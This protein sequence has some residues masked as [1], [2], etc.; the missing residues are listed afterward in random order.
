[1]S[2]WHWYWTNAEQWHLKLSLNPNSRTPHKWN[3]LPIWIFLQS[4]S[5][6]MQKCSWGFHSFKVSHKCDCAPPIYVKLCQGLSLQTA[7]NSRG[8]YRIK[9]QCHE[10]DENGWIIVLHFLFH[11]HNINLGTRQILLQSKFGSLSSLFKNSS[12]T[13]LAREA[14][15][16]TLAQGI[17]VKPATNAWLI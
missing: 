12:G 11:D 13:L 15:K 2:T 10:L 4:I 8:R 1:M 17:I 6:I 5:Q 14:F 7:A 9:W 16:D 3:I